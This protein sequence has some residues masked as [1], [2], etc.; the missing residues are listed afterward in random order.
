MTCNSSIVNTV[1]IKITRSKSVFKDVTLSYLDWLIGDVAKIRENLKW[2]ARV[3]SCR[4]EYVNVVLFRHKS[5]VNEGDS[6]Q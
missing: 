4:V 1:F 3:V 6:L 2:Q 5:A